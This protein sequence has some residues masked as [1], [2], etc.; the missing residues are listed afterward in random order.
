M[1]EHVEELRLVA[2][3]LAPEELHLVAE[4]LAPEEHSECEQSTEKKLKKQSSLTEIKIRK[5][6]RRSKVCSNLWSS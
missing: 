5:Q 3:E 6:I 1:F 4:E 2:E